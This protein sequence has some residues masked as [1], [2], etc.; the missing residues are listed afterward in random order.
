MADGELSRMH[1]HEVIRRWQRQESQ[2]AIAR[3]TGLAR[4][5]VPRYVAEAERLGLSQTVPRPRSVPSRR[6]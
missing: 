5:T 6:W 3:A 4:V 1:V 2:R